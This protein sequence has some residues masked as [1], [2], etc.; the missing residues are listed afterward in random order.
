[1]TEE[2]AQAGFPRKLDGTFRWGSNPTPW[3]FAFSVS[4]KVSGPTSYAYQVERSKFDEIL[5]D[6]AIRKGVE[7]RQNCSVND[8]VE[9]GDRITGVTY[10]DSEGVERQV[11]AK[12]VVDA[13]GNTSRIYERIGGSRK[14][15]ELFRSLALFGYFENGKR[16][17]PP[18]S[19][20]I[21]CAA[22]PRYARTTRTTTPL[23]RRR[24][25]CRGATCR[26]AHNSART[27]APRHRC[28]RVASSHPPMACSGRRRARPVDENPT[29]E[30]VPA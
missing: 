11:T 20:N 4:P 8:V 14:Y 19:G 9:D 29:L 28:S 12:Y 3:N 26:P 1:M 7:V 15:S 27:R 10:T 22:F 2:L 16:L 21:F 6:N 13:S 23:R 17:P 18:S 30:G 5:L 25:P 24:A